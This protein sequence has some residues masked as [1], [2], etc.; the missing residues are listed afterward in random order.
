[1]LLTMLVLIYDRVH[2]PTNVFCQNLIS[3]HG[4][5]TRNKFQPFDWYRKQHIYSYP[6]V[7]IAVLNYGKCTKIDDAFA[8][9]LDIGKQL[10]MLPSIMMD[11]VSYRRPMIVILNYGTPKP[12]M[13]CIV[14]HRRKFHFALNFIRIR[15]SN[16]FSLPE[17][18][19]R[20]SFA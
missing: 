16:I 5:A 18:Q 11:H 15:V 14:S 4:P 20:K 10:K 3:T 2:I 13:S 12:V 9:I 8:H 7:W 19:I 1:M 6:V 17:H